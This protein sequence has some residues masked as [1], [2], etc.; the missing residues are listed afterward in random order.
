MGADQ[1]D[2]IAQSRK[3]GLQIVADLPVAIARRVQR[4]DADQPLRERDERVAPRGHRLKYRVIIAHAG[5]L[6]RSARTRNPAICPPDAPYKGQ[7]EQADEVPGMVFRVGML[8][9]VVLTVFYV[10]LFLYIREGRKMRLEED[11]IAAGQPG[12]RAAWIGARLRPQ[13][14][15]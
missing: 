15:R 4:G 5:T 1:L 13:A 6:P 2:R 7:A 10:C 3:L 11:W 8:V 12:D 14:D 9:L